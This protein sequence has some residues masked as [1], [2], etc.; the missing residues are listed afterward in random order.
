MKYWYLRFTLYTGRKIFIIVKC[1]CKRYA[2]N[3]VIV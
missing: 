2:F 3:I 1:N